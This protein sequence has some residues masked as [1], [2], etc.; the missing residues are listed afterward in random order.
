MIEELFG[1]LIGK[2]AGGVLPEETPRNKKIEVGIVEYFQS[3]N[4]ASMIWRKI[5]GSRQY[6]VNSVPW[7][8][9]Q[10]VYDKGSYD[11]KKKLGSGGIRTYA[12]GE[13]GT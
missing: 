6:L 13:T 9:N 10:A 1:W 4:Q 7:C 11:A 12:S 8:F 2:T 3:A 5:T